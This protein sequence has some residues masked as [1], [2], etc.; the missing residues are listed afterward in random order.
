M[1]VVHVLE[2]WRSRSIGLPT[3]RLPVAAYIQEYLQLK[4]SLLETTRKV[5]GGLALYVFL[6][7]DG[8]VRS[9][10]HLTDLTLAP[11]HSPSHMCLHPS[12]LTCASC[13]LNLTVCSFMPLTRACAPRTCAPAC[14]PAPL[15]CVPP[16]VCLRP[17][18]VCQHPSHVCLRPSHVCMH[19]SRVS[20]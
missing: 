17:L 18:H 2:C 20:Y 9:G 11:Y 5:G 10:G 3:N 6:T 4:N 15:A 16:R 12:P 8:P 7:V 14:V 13:T 19:P 1:H